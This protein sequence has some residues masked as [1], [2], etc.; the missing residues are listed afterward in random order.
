MAGV[1]GQHCVVTP[2]GGLPTVAEDVEEVESQCSTADTSGEAATPAVTPAPTPGSGAVGRVTTH[3]MILSTEPPCSPLGATSS[4]SAPPPPP[5][6]LASPK[7]PPGLPAPRTPPGIFTT[8][9]PP[10]SAAA[11]AALPLSAPATP[12]GLHSE[13]MYT[14]GSRSH[15]L[16]LC[17]PCAFIFK[18]GCLSGENCKF[19]HLCQPGEKKRRRKERLAQRRAAVE[20]RHLSSSC[21]DGDEAPHGEPLQQQEEDEEEEELQSQP[22]L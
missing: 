10:T 6:A 2:Q 20:R 3:N 4:S 8:R 7:P 17:K 22:E 21:A 9:Y 18:D 16:G 19:C 15:E 12:T 13:A 14:V 11:A 5:A 1:R